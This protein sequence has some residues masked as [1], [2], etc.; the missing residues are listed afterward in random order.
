MVYYCERKGRIVGLPQPLNTNF[1]KEGSPDMGRAP[2][3][4]VFFGFIGEDENTLGG[5]TIDRLDMSYR[6][7]DYERLNSD[8]VAKHLGINLPE[9]CPDYPEQKPD[10]MRY[11][12]FHEHQRNI[13]EQ[14]E[15]SEAG[16]EY[17]EAAMAVKNELYERGLRQDAYGSIDFTIPLLYVEGT[18]Q[19][20]DWNNSDYSL[21]RPL[22]VPDGGRELLDIA[23]DI[24]ELNV[25]EPGWQLA[26]YHG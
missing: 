13:K 26:P 23:A 10:D 4:M 17:S 12:E 22:Q 11:S 14:W 8:A 20:H 21:N 15:Q 9:W 3:A 18:M 1:K 24:Y 19:D 2:H 6:D 16:Q 5:R 25:G 7:E